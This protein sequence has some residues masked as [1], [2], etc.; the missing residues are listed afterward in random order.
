[1][2]P[3]EIDI[4]GLMRDAFAQNAAA[5]LDHRRYQVLDDLFC[6]ELAPRYSQALGRP[7]DDVRHYKIRRGLAS[8]KG[9]MFARGRNRPANVIWPLREIVTYAGD[10]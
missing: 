1:V 7:L 3:N 5:F 6:T 9:S 4:A 8:L 10:N 2:N